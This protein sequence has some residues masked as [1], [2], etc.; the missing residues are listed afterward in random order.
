[1]LPEGA[2]GYPL[3]GV[4]VTASPAPMLYDDVSG[5]MFMPI[6]IQR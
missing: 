2:T 6:R 4:Q 3:A 1:L 5:M